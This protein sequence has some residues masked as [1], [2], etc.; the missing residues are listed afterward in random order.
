VWLTG[1]VGL[2]LGPSYQCLGCP[3]AVHVAFSNPDFKRKGF[4]MNF[5]F[6]LNLVKSI[7]C[8]ILV[9]NL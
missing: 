4:E 5:R 7:A 6:D 2:T 1:G 3:G 8:R 9:Q